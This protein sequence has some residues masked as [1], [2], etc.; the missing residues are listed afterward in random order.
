MYAS[1]RDYTETQWATIENAFFRASEHGY[2]WTM[3]GIVIQE[4]FV[5]PYI[6]KVFGEDGK[7]GSYGI[8]HVQLTTAMWLE[9]EDN[10]W[11]AKQDIAERL[12]LDDDYAVD[13]AIKKLNKV[14]RPKWRD[15]WAKYNG[16]G[17]ASYIYSDNI[18]SHIKNLKECTTLGYVPAKQYKY[19]GLDDI[20]FHSVPFYNTLNRDYYKY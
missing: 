1:C 9:R 6:V 7:Y 13:L 8:T 14:K 15:T 17:K 19:M 12:I 18:A 3:A 16:K 11:R 20:G 5:G 2:G 4:S 10:V